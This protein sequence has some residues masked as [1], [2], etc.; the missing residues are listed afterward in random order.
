MSLIGV[1]G[2]TAV[3]ERHHGNLLF[4]LASESWASSD[5]FKANGSH[6]PDSLKKYVAL[7]RYYIYHNPMCI[8]WIGSYLCSLHN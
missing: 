4:Q 7:M 6:D 5:K 2:T 1:D 8:D 3:A